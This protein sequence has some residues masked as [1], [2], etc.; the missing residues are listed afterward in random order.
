MSDLQALLRGNNRGY[1]RLAWKDRKG[2]VVV[3]SEMIGLC[4]VV[5]WW[6]LYVGVAWMKG[7]DE[8]SKICSLGWWRGAETGRLGALGSPTFVSK[9]TSNLNVMRPWILQDICRVLS[10][11]KHLPYR[12]ST[13][14]LSS[15]NVR[16]VFPQSVPKTTVSIS[17]LLLGVAYLSPCL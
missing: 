8:W 16:A 10:S 14:P 9:M 6:S 11:S 5:W 17:R 13:T 15:S 3:F 1:L 7:I 12:F 2:H 4:E